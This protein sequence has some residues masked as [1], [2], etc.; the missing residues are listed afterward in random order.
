MSGR[1]SFP[2]HDVAPFAL[3][4][5]VDAVLGDPASPWHPVATMGQAI[6]ACER[7]APQAPHLAMCYGATLALGGT[8]ACWLATRGLLALVDRYSP[9]LG[10]PIRV[11]VLKATFAVR[12][13]DE[14]ALQVAECLAAGDLPA[15]RAALGALV[16]RETS[17]LDHGRV[18][19]ATVE[20]VAENLTDSFVGPLLWYALLD[21][22]GAVAYRFVNTCDAMLGYRGRYEYLGK[23]AARLDDAL[24][25]VPARL[26]GASLV[27]A[28]A[29]AGAS[30]GGAWRTMWRYRRRTASPNAGWPMS[31]AAGALGVRL[32]KVGHYTLGC[33]PLPGHVAIHSAV[34]LVRAAA[35]LVFATYV[36]CALAR[37]AHAAAA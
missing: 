30:P 16:S 14:A 23:L 31:A 29:L 37:R 8:L 26:A 32:E 3:A 18:A 35:A 7:R 4:I 15:A 20:S 21:V 9:G 12:A 33:G 1:R 17:D 36:G 19:A 6:A 25:W 27:L 28:A 10:L 22:P 2:N 11:G 24:N 13:L 5:A 34:A